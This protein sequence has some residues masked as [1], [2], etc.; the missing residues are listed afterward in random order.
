MTLN[1]LI[2]DTRGGR[3]QRRKRSSEVLDRTT[4]ESKRD[5]VHRGR[6]NRRGVDQQGNVV[7]AR[8]F[9]RGARPMMRCHRLHARV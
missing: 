4:A 6:R 7:F 2:T 5:E 9:A 1:L 8:R 3:R